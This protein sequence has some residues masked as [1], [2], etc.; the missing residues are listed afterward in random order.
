MK[1]VF[2]GT[3]DYAVGSLEALLGAG[4]E[5]TGVVT[6]PDRPKGRS[7]QLRFS[8]VKECALAHGIPVFQ[9]ERI[10]RPEN[11][12]R[13]REFPADLFVVAAFGQILP[14]EILEMPR[15]GCINVHASLL[16][17]YR[18]ASPIQRVLLDGEKETG[19]T[20]M[21]MNEGVD[22][23]DIL[24]R[25]KIA[26]DPRETFATLHDKLMVLGGEALTEALALLEKGELTA[27]PQNSA[28]STYAPL[29]KKEDGELDLEKDVQVLDRQIR[30]MNPW[31]GA[32]THLKGKLLKIY[33]ADPV[34]AAELS[35]EAAGYGP[36]SVIRA[37]KGAFVIRCGSGA[38]KVRSLQL[39]GKKQMD[40][41]A[42]LAGA[43]L[44]PGEYLK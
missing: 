32:F 36:G 3:P 30:A 33:E 5:V 34:P 21:Q 37:E 23:G 20:V 41:A 25:K 39:E 2:M 16:P 43:K 9:P 35:E 1:I 42:F 7:G 8:P 11:V 12:E 18:G 44:L 15:Y 28:L 10:R 31:P 29:I 19:I 22:T 13:L 14:A 38:L 17:R 4:Y 27:T 40:A 24:Y 26:I 6:Q